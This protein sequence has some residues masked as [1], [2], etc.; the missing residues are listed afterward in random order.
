M[1][2]F[3]H[4][5]APAP[6]PRGDRLLGF[7]HQLPRPINCWLEAPWEGG[8]LVGVLG[9]AESVPPCPPPPTFLWEADASTSI[10]PGVAHNC[11]KQTIRHKLCQRRFAL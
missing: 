5:I 3:K 11:T 4:L 1:L 9:P 7:G 10:V 8:G 2:Q 6:T